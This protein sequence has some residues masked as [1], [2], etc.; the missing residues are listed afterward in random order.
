VNE[1]DAPGSSPAPK[2]ATPATVPAL[3]RLRRARAR[4]GWL[5]LAVALLLAGL[6]SAWSE[7]D[8]WTSAQFRDPHGGFV[9]DRIGWV[10]FLYK[11]MP[12]IGWVYFLG[13][14]AIIVLGHYLPGRVPFRWR[15][16][17]ASLALVSALGSWFVINALLKEHWGRARPRDVIELVANAPHHFSLALM[18]ADQ[19]VHNCS[20]TSGHAASGFVIMAVGLMGS[21][22]TRRRWL[23]IGLVAGAFASAGRVLQGGHFLSDTLFAGVTIWAT[24]WVVREVWLRRVAV[25]RKRDAERRAAASNTGS[26]LKT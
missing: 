6:F 21:V 20:F 16:R 15:R 4:A 17:A 25:R 18:P 14:L 8:L 19:C 23:A 5:G 9:G 10:V 2:P 24:G 3:R 26:G 22:A 13:S 11:A 12:R 1:T 7:L